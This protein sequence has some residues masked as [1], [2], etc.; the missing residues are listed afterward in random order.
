MFILG[1]HFETVCEASETSWLT[2]RDQISDVSPSLPDRLFFESS[3]VTTLF[4]D[5][6]NLGQFSRELMCRFQM[7]QARR[8]CLGLYHFPNVAL[9]ILI[10]TYADTFGQ[11]DEGF[12][13]LFFNGSPVKKK[14]EWD[15]FLQFSNTVCVLPLFE[16]LCIL[17]EHLTS[18][19]EPPY[20]HLP[21][22]K[23]AYFFILV[24]SKNKYLEFQY[25]T[26]TMYVS[27][28]KIHLCTQLTQKLLS[29]RG[30]LSATVAELLCTTTFI[31][32]MRC[33]CCWSESFQNAS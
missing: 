7:S 15:T 11:F 28:F 4:A 18:V 24:T 14:I 12:A 23:L 20:N 3:F 33:W 5:F 32:V 27:Q 21:S 2:F 16:E 30:I 13:Q 26:S 25:V 31:L 19:F 8:F 1:R 17:F 9:R 10:F 29:K 6:W 22:L